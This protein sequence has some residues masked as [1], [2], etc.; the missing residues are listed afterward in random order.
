MQLEIEIKT[1]HPYIHVW[2]DDYIYM[3]DLMVKIV[4]QR[5]FS[6]NELQRYWSDSF[7]YTPAVVQLKEAFCFLFHFMLLYFTLVYLFLFCFCFLFLFLVL[8]LFCSNKKVQKNNQ[9]RKQTKQTRKNH[10]KHIPYTCTPPP[11]H[12]HPHTHTHTHTRTKH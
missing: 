12:M 10:K 5:L 9:K 3:Y 2:F 6:Y 1:L 7:A 4:H 8:L 11:L